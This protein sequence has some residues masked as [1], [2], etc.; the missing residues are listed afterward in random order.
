MEAFWARLARGFSV[1]LPA[2]R[3]RRALGADLCEA[4]RVAGFLREE[5]I[6]EGDPY[7]CDEHADVGCARQVVG[8]PACGAVAACGLDARQCDDE[9]IGPTDGHRLVLDD[10]CF[11][12]AITEALGLGPAPRGPH[13]RGT[14]VH[15]G[16]REFGLA[17]VRF[18]LVRRAAAELSPLLLQ[19][20]VPT[21]ASPVVLIAAHRSA[22][23]SA[24]LNLTRAPHVD[25]L[26]LNE[27][28]SLAGDRLDID[29]GAWLLRARLPAL[30]WGRALFPR[31]WPVIDLA[32]DRCFW[33]GRELR[34]AGSDKQ[35]ELLLAL[36]ERPGTALSRRS[37]QARVWAEDF[38]PRGHAT[39][40]VEILD[41]RLRQTRGALERAFEDSG[42]APPLPAQPVR[43]K[44]LHDPTE[45][46][47]WLDLPSDRVLI[48][49]THPSP[50]GT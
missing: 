2:I 46:S 49:P 41:T 32:T 13:V 16:S 12:D 7:P 14:P 25:W 23:P 40:D 20:L 47:I 8:D 45:G 30:D 26:F 27:T 9:P 17:E 37:L 29:L 6:L 10:D 48:V 36:A 50:S 39:V 18:L 43:F 35:R 28:A 3:M 31:R 19:V 4:L 1:G 5:P 34:L 44:K 22:V 42:A 38:T 11:F 24:L 33:S 21:R 15:L